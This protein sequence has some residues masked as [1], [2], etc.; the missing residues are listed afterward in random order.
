M[1]LRDIPKDKLEKIE[2]FVK[3]KRG[4]VPV[5]SDAENLVDL[6][7]KKCGVRLSPQ[8][9]Y[10]LQRGG[11]VYRVA[12][13]EDAAATLKRRFG[14]VA[15]GLRKLVSEY[16]RSIGR[17][18]PAELVEAHEKLLAAAKNGK[19]KIRDVPECLGVPEEK[20]W[21]IV[22]ELSKRNL[23]FRDDDCYV[24]YETPHDPMLALLFAR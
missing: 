17:E 5:V 6:I 9:V 10:R 23:V 2:K 21:E 4:K 24:V 18:M 13:P 14:G 15:E 16:V 3:E 19:I 1:R 22:R 11:R 12:L 8:Q 20:A 7:E